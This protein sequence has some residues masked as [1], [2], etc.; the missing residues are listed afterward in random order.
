MVAAD[1][2]RLFRRKPG[3]TPES[4]RRTSELEKQ[5]NDIEARV[6][7]LKAVG[8]I[9]TVSARTGKARSS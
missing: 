3:I 7:R 1:A 4:E 9:V 5:V 6:E 2:M 8:T